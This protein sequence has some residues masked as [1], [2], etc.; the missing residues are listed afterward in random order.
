MTSQPPAGSKPDV[1]AI[2]VENLEAWAVKNVALRKQIAS[3]ESDLARV[4]VENERL[5]EELFASIN[6]TAERAEEIALA[7]R[8]SIRDEAVGLLRRLCEY[9]DLDQCPEFR[10]DLN[11]FLSRL[12]QPQEK[13][14]VE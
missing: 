7:C 2:L 6:E 8:D 4:T 14:D 11:A 1:Q 10:D 5:Q 3:L 9:I 13:S 12:D